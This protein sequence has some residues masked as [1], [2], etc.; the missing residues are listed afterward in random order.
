MLWN[1][2]D[3]PTLIADY[4]QVLLKFIAPD[5]LPQYLGGSLTDSDGDPRCHTLVRQR[6][7]NVRIVALFYGAT[8][9]LMIIP[10]DD[11]HTLN[12]EYDLR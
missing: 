11:I 12:H 4:Q 7:H 3:L 10:R 1:T 6:G 2:S 9:Q 8:R 5:N